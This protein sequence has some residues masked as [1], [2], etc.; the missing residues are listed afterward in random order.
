MCGITE[1]GCGFDCGAY[2]MRLPSGVRRFDRK[3]EE[4]ENICFEL[5]TDGVNPDRAIRDYEAVYAASWKSE[6][7]YPKFT[8]GLIRTSTSMGNCEKIQFFDLIRHCALKN[9]FNNGLL[10][11]W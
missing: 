10:I 3:F 9:N 11:E 4:A 8:S 2:R 1:I 5:T 6:E 7:A